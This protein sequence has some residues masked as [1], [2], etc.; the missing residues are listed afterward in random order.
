MDS[1]RVTENE[2]GTFTLK[3]NPEDPKWQFLNEM[4]Q[5]E[6]ENFVNEALREFIKAN[7]G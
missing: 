7:G 3:W 4:P 1:I 2:D 6:V 5:E